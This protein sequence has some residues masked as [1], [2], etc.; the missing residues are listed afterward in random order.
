MTIRW[1]TGEIAPF[2]ERGKEPLESP[3]GELNARMSNSE[4]NYGQL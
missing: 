2:R 4:W 1:T 3:I